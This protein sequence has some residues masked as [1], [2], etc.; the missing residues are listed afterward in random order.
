MIHDQKT[1]TG[2][3]VTNLWRMENS[4]NGSCVGTSIPLI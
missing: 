4:L 2:S 1:L 3:W